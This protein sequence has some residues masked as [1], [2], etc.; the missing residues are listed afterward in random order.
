MATVKTIT[1]KV[2]TDAQAKDLAKVQSTLKGI[3][4]ERNKLINAQAKGTELTK[5]ESERL[6]KLTRDQIKG[7]ETQRK[8]TQSTKNLLNANN[9]AVGSYDKL[10]AETA[11]L[12]NRLRQLPNAFDKTNVAANRLKKQIGQNTDKFEK[13]D[14]EIGQNFRNV[15]NYAGALKG[16]VAGFGKLAAGI[17]AGLIALRTLQRVFGDV[18]TIIGDFEQSQARLAS[19]LGTTKESIGS[20]STAAKDLGATTAFTA[21]EVSNLQ[22]EFAKL[23]F[24][25]DEILAATEATLALA[26]A[27]QSDL[28][29]AAK[30]AG[31]T[32]RAFGLSAE[33]TQRVVDVM[34][35]SFS[36][37]A[38]DLEKF[39]VAM[40]QVAPV[41]KNAGLT[42]E[43]TTAFIGIL[44]DR[45]VDASTAGTGLRNVFLE[46]AKQGISFNEAME[47]INSSTNKNA[48]ALELFGKRGATIA[49]ILAE[50]GDQAAI[51]TGKLNNSAGA[52]QRMADEQLN[53]LQGRVTILN[54]AWEGFILSLED[55]SGVIGGFVKAA[56]EGL[57]SAISGLTIETERNIQTASEL[58]TQNTNLIAQS[59]SLL[60]TYEDLTGQEELN[61]KQKQELD[62]VTNDL[63]GIFGEEIIVLD[64]DTGAINLN[65]VAIVNQIRVRQALQSEQVK[66]LLGDQLRLETQIRTNEQIIA[67]GKALEDQGVTLERLVGTTIVANAENDKFFNFQKNLEAQGIKLTNVQKEQ[68]KILLSARGATFALADAERELEIIN[69]ALLGSGIDLV[70][71][72]KELR[73]ENIKT[74]QDF[75]TLGTE[76]KTAAEIRI[77]ALRSILEILKETEAERERILTNAEQFA[78][79]RNEARIQRDLDAAASTKSRVDSELADEQRLQQERLADLQ[80]FQ[81]RTNEVFNIIANFQQASLNRQ[82][83]AAEGNE[84]KQDEI[85]AKFGKKRKK[86]ATIEAAING[87]VAVTRI[88]ADVPKGDFGISTALLIAAAV[89]LTASEIALI[90]SQKFAKG[91]LLTG[92]SHVWG[93]IPVSVGGSRV[94][95]AEGGEAIINKRSTQMYTPLLSAINEAGGGV[96]FAQSGTIVPTFSAPSPSASVVSQNQAAQIAD[97]IRGVIAQEVGAL[98]VI[99][100]ATDTASVANTAANIE[101]RATFG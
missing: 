2:V 58:T 70:A 53:T 51:L 87:A 24:S 49:T 48:T 6:T 84:E 32:V 85:R 20:L 28:A 15:G 86:A 17:G 43:D 38:L 92:S 56:I 46:L 101:S 64:K 5:K 8:L 74:T 94:V 50:T 36:S 67:T 95:E 66:G 25:T 34:A 73:T 4:A 11:I 40:R 57:T 52:A 3:T 12:R 91:G 55:G 59:Q 42:I 98:E 47:R 65:T 29:T 21:T 14:K 18:A 62:D 16:A 81:Q 30:V 96:A 99:N 26:A 9:A 7:R 60:N 71:I 76:E 45:G 100:V 54:S 63:I 69:E 22:T 83:K 35:K 93:G 97:T 89:A 68:L 41:A 39:E 77:A 72:A 37:S 19:I 88:L 13:F 10:V 27:T 33:D 31:S 61:T 80:K 78:Q 82:L 79:E 23:G 1:I 90:Q 44:A 75:K